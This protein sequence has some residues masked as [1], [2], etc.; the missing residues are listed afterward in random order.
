MEILQV[1]KKS[2][3]QLKRRSS[4]NNMCTVFRAAVILLQMSIIMSSCMIQFSAEARGE[5][6]WEMLVRNAGVSAMHMTLAHTNKVIMFDRTDY[7]PSEIRLANGFC[8]RDRRDLAL[9]VDCWA[10]SIELDL[11]TNRVRP[12]TV[13]TDTWCSSG[14]WQAGGTLTQTGGWNDGGNTVRTIGAGGN[15]DWREYPNALAKA[16]WYASNQLLPDQRVIVIGGRRQFNYEFVPRGRE[17]SI[18]LPFLAETNDRGAENNLYPFVHLSPDGNLFIFANKDSILF[19]YKRNQVVRRYPRLPGGSRNYPAS[20]S[21][22]LLPLSAANRYTRA[23]VLVCG[24]APEGSFQ[25]TYRGEFMPAEQTCGRLV[26]TDAN[27]NWLVVKMPSPRVMG[28]MLILPTG[29]VLI[30]NGASQGTAGWGL[31]RQPNLAPVLFT[32]VNNRFQV[33]SETGI[34]RLYHSTANVMPDGSVLVGGSNPNFGYTFKGTLFP[35]ELSIQRY[36]PYYLNKGYDGRR[37]YI[38]AISNVN[39]GYGTSFTVT[40]HTAQALNGVA[41]HLYAPPFTTHTYSMNQRMLVL[42]SNAPVRVGR[43]YV[44]RVYAPPNAVTAPSAYHLLTVVNQGTPSAS[45]WV[46]IG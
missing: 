26:I 17:G 5:D 35:T 10:H 46:H 32:P 43:S 11:A 36:N 4:S 1:G 13:L 2:K 28:D 33:M 18:E 24:G 31:G 45:A 9:Q 15:D 6:S 30:I 40:Y 38:T 25:A 20:G 29:E 8:R 42:G 27:P 41:F 23:D 7:G 22:V 16:R 39:L 21:S 14:A 12:L 37:P 44:S 19:N 34:P 3:Q